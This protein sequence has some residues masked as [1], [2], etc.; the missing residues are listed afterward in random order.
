MKDLSPD[1]T[2]AALDEVEKELA[3]HPDQREAVAERIAEI[4]GVASAVD[5]SRSSFALGQ[6]FEALRPLRAR[7]A[8][9]AQRERLIKILKNSASNDSESETV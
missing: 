2:R 1:Q 6:V 9:V 4:M 5:S 8:L 7:K 3:R